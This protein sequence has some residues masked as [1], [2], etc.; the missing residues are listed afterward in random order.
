[1]PHRGLRECR[2]RN[3]ATRT[4]DTCGTVDVLVNN[5]GPGLHVPLEELNPVDLRAIF[6]LNVVAPLVGMQTVLPVMR[7]RSGGAIVNVS[8]AT[9]LRVF[10]GLGGYAATKAAASATTTA[11]FSSTTGESVRRASSPYRAA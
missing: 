9:S 3:A 1:M 5:A 4:V 11:R 7:A 6:E 8:S 2:L 10:S